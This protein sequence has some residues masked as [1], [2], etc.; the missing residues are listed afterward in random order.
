[1]AK[2]T[3]ASYLLSLIG[4]IFILLG[5][6]F[7]LGCGIG[8]CGMMFMGSMMGYMMGGFGLFGFFNYMSVI[9]IASGIVI[10]YGAFMIKNRPR[11][12]KTWG[13]LVLIFSLI[14]LFS[15]GGFFVGAILGILGGIFALSEK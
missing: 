10:L 5:S 14:S 1:M 3:N 6:L 9:G 4:G 13:L 2:E 7:V 15:M 11:E 8:A 12:S